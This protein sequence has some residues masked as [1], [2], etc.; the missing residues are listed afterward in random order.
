MVIASTRSAR[1][2]SARTFGFAAASSPETISRLSGSGSG[3]SSSDTAAHA[4]A[5]PRPFAVSGRKKA[6]EPGLSARPSS[7]ASLARCEPPP[8]PPPD[9]IKIARSLARRRS[10]RSPRM[11]RRQARAVVPGAVWMSPAAPAD[12]PERIGD[13]VLGVQVVEAEAALVTEPALVD[14]RVVAGEDPPDFAFAL[15]GVDVAADRAKSA[16]G[17]DALQLPGSDLKA[18]LR[19]Q[20]RADRAELG[21]VAG[22]RAR[23]GLVLEGRDERL[24]AAVQG[25]ELVV[26]GNRLAEAR[27]AVAEDAALAVDRDRGRD[28]DR[29]LEGPLLE[30]HPR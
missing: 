23:V 16:D 4:S 21:H 9:Q 24:R 22:E 11:S 13:P 20:Q 1:S 10:P 14:L 26:L 28:R 12:A 25:D 3:P 6:P 5:T 7:A 18:R 8:A 30:G 2:A 19:R 15:V 17:R 29:L 27:A